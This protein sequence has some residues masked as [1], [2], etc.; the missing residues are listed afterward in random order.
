[1]APVAVL[2]DAAELALAEV[3][4]LAAGALLLALDVLLPHAAISRVAAPAAA[5][6]ATNEVCL[7]FSS[8]GPVPDAHARHGRSLGQIA[9]RLFRRRVR[10]KEACPAGGTSLQNCDQERPIC[11]KFAPIVRSRS[12][13][14]RSPDTTLTDQ[15][16]ACVPILAHCCLGGDRLAG[17]ARRRDRGGAA[18]VRPLLTAARRRRRADRRRTGRHRLQRGKRVVR[19][20]AVRRVRPGFGVARHRARRARRRHPGARRGRGRRRGRRPAAAVRPVPAAPRRGRRPGA[21]RRHGRRPGAAGRTAARG[22]RRRGPLVPPGVVT[23]RTSCR[24]SG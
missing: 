20:H 23:C 6:V 16:V 24:S 21:P 8:T 14:F 9:R 3:D 13:T 19:P 2:D 17:A 1:M 10:W 18:R 11:P 12:F 4:V 15:P 22:L 5:T 7:T